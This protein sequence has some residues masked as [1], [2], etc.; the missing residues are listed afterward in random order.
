MK[1][2]GLMNSVAGSGI[3]KYGSCGEYSIVGVPHICLLLAMEGE[4]MNG[5]FVHA[6]D[7]SDSDAKLV[8]NAPRPT[9]Q[10]LTLI[11]S[12]APTGSASGASAIGLVPDAN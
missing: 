10:L 4:A 2:K 11:A 7:I 5:V 3:L 12:T 8:C 9:D 6:H 1:G